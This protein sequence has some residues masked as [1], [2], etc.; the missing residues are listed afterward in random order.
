MGRLGFQLCWE[1][2]T[3]LLN[4]ANSEVLVSAVTGWSGL[5]PPFEVVKFPLLF[6]GNLLAMN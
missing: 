6:G 2:K 1:A 5:E 3:Q 4:M